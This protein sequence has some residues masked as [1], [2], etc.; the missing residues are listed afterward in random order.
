MSTRLRVQ[1]RR[2]A[3]HRSP[4]G[5]DQLAVVE[6]RQDVA[7]HRDE[8]AAEVGD[9]RSAPGGAER[10]VLPVPAQ[11]EVV[12]QRVRLGEVDLDQLA[13][14]ADAEVDRRAPRG[15]QPA[16]DV[17]E[18]RPVAD[19]YQRLRQDRRVRPQ[20]RAEARLPGSPPSWHRSW[21][22]G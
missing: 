8:R 14:M 11:L 20:A 15:V 6:R 16:E 3:P 9:D 1:W 10:L 4:R 13:E 2:S 21:A 17:L 12:R 7:V 5:T 19:G 18:D 22:E